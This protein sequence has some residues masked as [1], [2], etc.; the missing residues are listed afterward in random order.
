[1]MNI[2]YNHKTLGYLGFIVFL[3]IFTGFSAKSAGSEKI[4]VVKERVQLIT[5]RDLY[6]AGESLFFTAECH[7]KNVEQSAPMST[8]LYAE[9]I[10]VATKK[11]VIQKKY[12]I[13]QNRVNGVMEIP[14]GCQSGNYILT[15]YTRYQQNFPDE[16]MSNRLLVILNPGKPA[17][18]RYSSPSENGLKVA[19]GE[20]SQVSGDSLFSLLSEPVDSAAVQTTAGIEGDMMFYHV[21]GKGLKENDQKE[22]ILTLVNS[23]YST[24]ESRKIVVNTKE[25]RVEYERKKCDPGICF[26][27][28]T[29]VNGNLV[30]INS[31]FNP[32]ANSGNLVIETDKNN[33][34]PGDEVRVTLRAL[35]GDASIRKNI[36]VSVIRHGTLKE[37][38]GFNPWI[39]FKNPRFLSEYLLADP[40]FAKTETDRMMILLDRFLNQEMFLRLLKQSREFTLKHLPENRDVSLHGILINNAGLPVSG[41]KMFVS[42]LD[43]QPQLHVTTTDERGEFIFSLPGLKGRHNLFLCPE[44]QDKNEQE[45]VVQVYDPFMGYIPEMEN[46][47]LFLDTLDMELITEAGLNAGVTKKWHPLKSSDPKAEIPPVFNIGGNKTTIHTSDYITLKSM[48]ELFTEIVPN[49]KARK[50]RGEYELTIYDSNG[51]EFSTDPLVLVDYVP[52]FDPDALMAIDPAQVEKTEV[53]DKVYVLGDYTFNG[54][55]MVTTKTKNYSAISLPGSGIF[56][57]FQGLES[58]LLPVGISLVDEPLSGSKPDF[59]TTLYWNPALDPVN[60][61]TEFRFRTSHNTGIYDIVVTESGPAGI[62][63]K[64]TKQIRV[65]MVEK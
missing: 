1:M 55:V 64:T 5:D 16:E 9:L 42:V 50:A 32:Q 45:Y 6:F 40:E 8:V 20:G 7:L 15:V 61:G 25:Q 23:D 19:A 13:T 28:L 39:S 18:V 17:D 21:A 36:T 27:V 46:L 37:H 60:S 3:I 65:E 2:Q 43:N 54:V 11:P 56:L 38:H 33:Y 53:I 49:V 47:P 14:D 24:V 34:L 30:K 62:I 31:L 22:Y 51:N 48:N 29:D 44:I 26:F 59:H 52:I 41:K 10:E 12:K 4:S 58:D 35:N 57:E 63:A